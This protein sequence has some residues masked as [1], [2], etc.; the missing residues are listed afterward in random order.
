[1]YIMYFQLLYN[2]VINDI[3]NIIVDYLQDEQ[4][5]SR[6][7]IPEIQEII[8]DYVYDA[9]LKYQLYEN[10]RFTIT[11]IELDTF[12]KPDYEAGD[13]DIIDFYNQPSF[14]RFPKLKKLVSDVFHPYMITPTLEHLELKD[15]YQLT[16][17]HLKAMRKLKV[18]KI[19]N[20]NNITVKVLI[21]LRNLE[22][23][24]VQRYTDSNKQ[25]KRFHFNN[26]E[27]ELKFETFWYLP[28]L[29]KVIF[30]DKTMASQLNI[31][32]L[33][34]NVLRIIS[35]MGNLRYSN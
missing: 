27:T 25:N 18:L 14:T 31:Y 19:P 26:E 20:N 1:M 34:Y 5:L 29:R 8:L 13:I 32:A 17:T 22:V 30:K 12:C 21:L 24:E 15:S 6:R 10:N 11:K 23:L 28:K 35:D 16:N 7:V 3:S 33:N 9:E 2:Y 4:I